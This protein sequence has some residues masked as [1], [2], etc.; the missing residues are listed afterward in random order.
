MKRKLE[1][2]PGTID[3]QKCIRVGAYRRVQ[4]DLEGVGSGMLRIPKTQIICADGG[5]VVGE[6]ETVHLPQPNN[7]VLGGVKRPKPGDQN[8]AEGGQAKQAE[9]GL[10]GDRR[11]SDFESVPA[12]G[13]RDRR[14]FWV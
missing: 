5:P 9:N 12:T 10:S 13:G 2:A 4:P 1:R 8:G 6:G 3:R 11:V 14:S 7:I